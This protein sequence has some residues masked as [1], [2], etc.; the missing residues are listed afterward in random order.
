MFVYKKQRQKLP[1]ED[2]PVPD[3][4]E[5]AMVIRDMKQQIAQLELD[6]AAG[7]SAILA[8]LGLAGTTVEY[9]LIHI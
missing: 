2:H 8:H 7:L 6:G 5:K 9:V 4:C 1:V 3:C